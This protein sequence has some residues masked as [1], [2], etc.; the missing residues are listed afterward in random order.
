MK[1]FISNIIAGIIVGYLLLQF[2]WLSFF[3][4]II[5]ILLY[6]QYFYYLKN[7]NFIN[8]QIEMRKYPKRIH[9]LFE[10]DNDYWH[11]KENI[12]KRKKIAN[13]SYYL[14]YICPFLSE[15]QLIDKMDKYIQK[16]NLEINY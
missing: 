10:D 4:A 6:I 16:H 11:S 14:K 1:N 12:F 5:L 7:K 15:D 2:S 13:Y 9:L 8:D 3:S